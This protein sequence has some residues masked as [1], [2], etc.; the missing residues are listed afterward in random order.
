MDQK[1]NSTTSLSQSHAGFL[2]LVCLAVAAVSGCAA[3]GYSS[4]VVWRVKSPDG[5]LVAVCQQVPVFDGPNY[6]VRLERPDGT[7]VRQLYGIGDGDPCSEVV[8]SP[9]GQL[10]AVL[11]AHV[12]LVRFVD[13]GW[14][15][16][17]PDVQTAA[18]SWRMVSLS[19]ERLHL[20]GHDLRFVGP[21]AVELVA[22]PAIR[23]STGSCGT[24]STIR[25]FEIPQPVVTGHK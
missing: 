10:L 19:T 17:H 16:S 5:Q 11:S 3:L 18:W 22:C 12:A 21:M 15:L 23:G 24:D 4:E 6:D 7:V 14:A 25:R 9:D 13:V 20:R 1:R 8:W 2:G